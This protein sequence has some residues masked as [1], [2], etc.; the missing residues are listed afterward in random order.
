M[1]TNP[2]PEREALQAQVKATGLSN[3]EIGRGS[4][5]S[6]TTISQWLNNKYPGDVGAVEASLRSWL[7][8]RIVRSSTGVSTVTTPLST[9]VCKQL[10]EVRAAGELVLFIGQAGIGK[11]RS[12]DCYVREHPLTIAFR[13][14]P[15]HSGMSG[16]ADDLCRATDIHRIPAGQRRWDVIVEKTQGCGRMLLVD[17]A[18]ELGPRGLQCCVDY[19]EQTG[20]PVA[21]FGLPHL[22]QR[23]LKDS[24]RAR[25]IAECIEVTC[26][27]P[28]P[29][30]H[31]LVDELAHDAAEERDQVIN[32][33]SQIASGIGCFGSVEKQLKL[34]ARERK[35]KLE[36]LRS[37][38]PEYFRADGLM[39]WVPALR[40]VHARLLRNQSL[41]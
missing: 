23:L 20:N 9:R 41:N 33:C 2:S 11:T 13:V 22:K 38:H 28:T 4:G 29:L 24:R 16:L 18:H 27:D 35:K 1:Q 25:R 37:K 8:D 6:K 36:T 30:L 34:A 31:H 39:K 15:W 40:G 7:R 5:V 14:L 12:Q 19:H 21:L 32:L 10:E 17:D 3:A 26:D